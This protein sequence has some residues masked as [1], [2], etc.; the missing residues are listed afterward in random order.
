M[1]VKKKCLA[2]LCGQSIRCGF[3]SFVQNHPCQ[4]EADHHLHSHRSR[5]KHGM[6][7]RFRPV[8]KYQRRG[9]VHQTFVRH[10]LLHRSDYPVEVC[11]QFNWGAPN[12][13]SLLKR[14][15]SSTWVW[16]RVPESGEAMRAPFSATLPLTLSV[17]PSFSVIYKI[18]GTQ[19]LHCKTIPSFFFL[20]S[21]DTF[22]SVVFF[23]PHKVSQLWQTWP[24][25][26]TPFPKASTPSRKS[27]RFD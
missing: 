25:L 2:P 1:I 8:L 9:R 11:W 24:K 6:E 19:W 21:A 15:D 16:T 26:L 13:I 12:F 4:S 7:F 23:F 17:G 20:K 27:T 10:V 3:R 5:R 14:L 22:I 18:T